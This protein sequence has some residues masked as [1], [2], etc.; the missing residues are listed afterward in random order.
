MFLRACARSGLVAADAEL[1]RDS[2]G[3]PGLAV[4][5]FDRVPGTG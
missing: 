4:A 1:L 2:E 3:H 5:R